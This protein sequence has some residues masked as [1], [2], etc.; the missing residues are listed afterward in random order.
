M[1]HPLKPA[2]ADVEKVKRI[3]AAVAN[4]SAVTSA[5]QAEGLHPTLWSKWKERAAEDVDVDS[6]EMAQGEP[7]TLAWAVYTIARAQGKAWCDVQQRLFSAKLSEAAGDWRCFLQW[8]IRM[9][10]E[11]GDKQTVTVETKDPGKVAA[12]LL[13][14]LKGGG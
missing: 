13:A 2:Y 1:G 4:G 7:G 3:E 11:M 6:G 10:P 9:V 5:F 14:E 12:E 8:A